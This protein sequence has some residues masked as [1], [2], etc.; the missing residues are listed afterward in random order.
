MDLME[1]LGH[2]NISAVVAGTV[3]LLDGKEMEQAEKRL[4]PLQQMLSGRTDMDAQV[5]LNM[6]FARLEEVAPEILDAPIAR[7]RLVSPA[8]GAIVRSTNRLSK[9][10]VLTDSGRF[11][12]TSHT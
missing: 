4:C 3:I 7:M 12:Y 10:Q 6:L 2:D 1:N 5:Y 11:D 8:E 9:K